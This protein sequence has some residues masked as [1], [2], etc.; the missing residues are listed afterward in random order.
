MGVADRGRGVKRGAGRPQ[1]GYYLA[2]G[3]RVPGSTTVTGR[4]K[5]SGGL[6]FVAKRNWHEAG[7]LGKPFSPDAYWSD[8]DA[9]QAGT[10]VH[11]WIER[12]VY[13]EPITYTAEDFPDASALTLQQ[14]H[15][16]YM[17]Y[18]QWRT[19]VNLEILETEVPLVSETYGY[20][21]TLDA[22]A[23]V[24]GER[25]IFDWKTSNGTY[26]DYIAQVAAYRQLVNETADISETEPIRSAHLL[27]VDKEFG[28][29]HHHWWPEA[30]LDLGWTWFLAAKELYDADKRLKKVAS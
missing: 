30:V 16:G 19:A 11:D 28:S 21:G 5:D 2:D 24:N 10:L 20:G 3:T 26:P 14:A 25:C 12:D 23:L 29:F 13:D 8:G 7:R 6:V 9:L 1:N 18:K 27:R 22:I 15:I 17:A 4:G